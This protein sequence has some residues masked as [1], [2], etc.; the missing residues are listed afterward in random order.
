MRDAIFIA[1]FGYFAIYFLLEPF[2]ANNALWIALLLFLLLRGL[3]MKYF[4][5]KVIYKN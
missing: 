5:K 1:T 4:A 3:G 2:I